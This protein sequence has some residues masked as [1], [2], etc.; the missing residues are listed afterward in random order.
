[1]KMRIALTLLCEKKDLLSKRIRL[2]N[3][4]SLLFE[5]WLSSWL[6]ASCA[7]TCALQTLTLEDTPTIFKKDIVTYRKEL[8]ALFWSTI[9]K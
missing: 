6:Y 3:F 1:M 4:N 9:E 5:P 2:R 7:D 8:R